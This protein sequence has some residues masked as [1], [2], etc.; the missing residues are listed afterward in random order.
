MIEQGSMEW[1]A[2]R[3][4]KI[5]ASR[6]GDLTA[7]TKTGWG[8]SR[9]AYVAE[10]VVERLTGAPYPSFETQAMRWGRET[11]AQARDAY[12]FYSGVTVELVAFVDHPDL[13]RTGASPDGRVGADGLVEIKCP[14]T[15][16]HI[17]RLLGAPIPRGHLLQMQWQMECDRRQ[18]CDYVSFDP[19]VPEE[20]RLH[21][22]RIQ[23][24]DDVIAELRDV[25]A[26]ADAEVAAKVAALRARYGITRED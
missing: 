13:P 20:M 14:A 2:R 5:T 12:T 22:E 15:A 18:W 8:A 4:G 26:E 9:A 1:Y 7:R 3:V 25:I 17:E 21:V 23:R 24:D 19:R 10:L 11:E 16:T 6:L